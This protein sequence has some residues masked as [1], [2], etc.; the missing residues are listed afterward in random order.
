MITTLS[1]QI[2]DKIIIVTPGLEKDKMKWNKRI[3]SCPVT[4]VKLTICT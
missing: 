2:S 3:D 1:T 4:L